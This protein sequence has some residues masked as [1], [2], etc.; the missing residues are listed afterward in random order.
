[1]A[2]EVNPVPVVQLGADRDLCTG[3]ALTL[4]PG[5]F[6]QYRW[7]DGSA[8]RTFRA[9]E[10]GL[11]HVTVTNTRG[12]TGS[13]SLQIGAI[14]PSPSDF[15]QASVTFCAYQEVTLSPTRRFNEYLWSTGAR[16]QTITVDRGGRYTLE[17]TDLNG[18]R[19]RD[20]IQVIEND[21]LTGVFIPNA[22]TPNGDNLNDRFLAL[23][24]GR[25]E[26]FRLE[27]YNR[28]GELVYATSDPRQGW[29]GNFKGKQSPGGNFV[30]V[31]RYQLAG[32]NPVTKKGT[33]MLIR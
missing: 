26:S 17:V 5:N 2:L 14:L 23:V 27:V 4:D 12:C 11:Y 9:T 15:L 31:C 20:T 30:W 8:N 6:S 1:M 32:E 28:F 29:D 7:Q 19:G 25:V 18:C 3:E 22:F 13:D 24:Y 10:A 21:C 16:Q 33:V